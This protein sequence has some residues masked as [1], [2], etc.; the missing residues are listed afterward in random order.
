MKRLFPILLI[1]CFIW[2]SSAAAFPAEQ[3][4]S[5]RHDAD[6]GELRVLFIN[7]GKADAALLQYDDKAFLID[8][9]GKPSAPVLIGA[10]NLFGADKLDGVFLTHADSDHAGGLDAL[11]T[12]FPVETLYSSVFS[13][14]KKNGKNKIEDFARD[15]SLSHIELEANDKV[16]FSKDVYFQVLGPLV[17][18]DQD[19]NDNSLVF[20]LTLFGR[21]LLFMGDA[22]FAGEEKLLQSGADLR[23]D[24]LKTGNHGNPD[25]TSE[26]FAAAVSPRY[27]VISTD[28]K[29]DEDS[30]NE[31]VLA[32]LRHSDVFL[33]QDF[34]VGVLVT[35]LK[36]GTILIGDPPRPRIL[37]GA[38]ITGV[39]RNTQTVT[40]KND[41]ADED[42]SGFMILSQRG[43]EVFVFPEGV[44]LQ[45]GQSVTV[46]AE[47]GADHLWQGED[48]VWHQE[49]QDSAFLYDR[50]GNLLS[51]WD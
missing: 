27:A 15:L 32:A 28:T 14:N 36:D 42:I 39:D 1:T 13:E 26:A 38:A 24:V 44:V 9:G 8:T 11:A 2:V 17:F 43:N 45:S 18:D 20:K 49:K 41:G 5:M 7:V 21:T 3:P 31:R 6:P 4:V 37:S 50:F 16:P 46:S 10:L 40:V 23:A 47:P 35:V 48:K 34:A 22:Q 29:V 19:G 25:A 12:N 51:K 33:T 30:A